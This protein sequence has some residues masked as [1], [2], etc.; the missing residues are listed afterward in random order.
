MKKFFYPI[1]KFFRRSRPRQRPESSVKPQAAGEAGIETISRIW[2]PP[3][4]LNPLIP[5][6]TPPQIMGAQVNFWSKIAEFPEFSR[7]FLWCCWLLCALT[8]YMTMYGSPM[9]LLLPQKHLMCLYSVYSACG[10]PTPNYSLWHRNSHISDFTKS[11]KQRIQ[12][13]LRVGDGLG[14][15]SFPTLLAIREDATNLPLKHADLYHTLN[16]HQKWM[17]FQP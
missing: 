5:E 4:I 14:V 3:Q 17:K 12:M 13:F 8:V 6:S 11:W 16:L 9:L 10:P 7:N 1:S 2:D 15:P